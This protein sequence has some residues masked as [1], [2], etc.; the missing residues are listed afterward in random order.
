V[1]LIFNGGCWLVFLWLLARSLELLPLRDWTRYYVV[2]AAGVGTFLSTFAVTLNNHLPAATSAMAALYCLLQWRK[3]GTGNASWYWLA[4]FA[5]ALAAAFELPAALLL[6]ATAL[7][8]ASK[9]LVRFVFCFLPAAL[10]V[11]GGFLFTNYLAHGDLRPPYAHRSDG[12]LVATLEGNFAGDLDR[13]L[14]PPLL[15]EVLKEHS[16]VLPQIA[17]ASWHFDGDANLKRWVV[18]DLETFKFT[19]VRRESGSRYE[20]RRW[21]HWYAYKGSYWISDKKSDVDQGEPDTAVYAF[22]ILFGHHG[23]F[24]LTPI[25]LLSLAGLAGLLFTNQYRLRWFA[26]M[27]VGI[28]MAV[29]AFYLFWVSAHDR[30]YGGQTSAFRWAFWLAPFWLIGMVPVVDWLSKS[31]QGR[32]ACLVALLLSALSAYYSAANPWVH[33]WLFQIWEWTDLPK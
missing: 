29:F 10:A 20:L 21:N 25:W 3:E 28:S 12:P 31:R 17:P 14:V 4:G 18:Q 22:H 23:V 15:S 33:P 9:S 13:G 2:A 5:S 32:T 6:V 16:L 7:T 26:F 27:A 11:I 24:S 30:N 8:A 1:L 19:I